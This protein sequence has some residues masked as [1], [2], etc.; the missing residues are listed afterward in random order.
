MNVQ[1]EVKELLQY[2]D[3]Q[4]ISTEDVMSKFQ[5]TTALF[6][7]TN[8]VLTEHIDESEIVTKKLLEAV[9]K[10]KCFPNKM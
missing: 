9:D 4:K 1:G 6:D 10:V 8:K 7:E 3:S 2:I 5:T